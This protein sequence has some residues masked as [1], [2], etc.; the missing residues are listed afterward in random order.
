M[1]PRQTDRRTRTLL[2]AGLLLLGALSLHRL[3]FAPVPGPAELRLTGTTMGTTWS[4]RLHAGGPVAAEQARAIIEGATWSVEASMSTYRD[5][6]EVSRLS[7]HPVGQAFDLSPELLRV[8]LS[9]LELFE[10]TGGAFDATVAPLVR[11]WGF[12]AGAALKAPD[13]AMLADA[14]RSVGFDKLVL[15]RQAATATRTVEG[16]EVDLSAIAK[17]FAVD[18]AADALERAGAKNY[19]VEVGGELR[20]AGQR[21]PS[22][23]WRVGVEAPREDGTRAVHRVLNPVSGCVATSGNYRNFRDTKAG[24][25]SHIIDPRVGKPVPRRLASVTVLHPRCTQADAWATALTVLGVDEGLA[26]AERE[27][28]AALLLTHEG[29]GLREHASSRFLASK[30][31]K[32]YR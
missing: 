29:D 11:L 26:V 32:P 23:P 22:S 4:A 6:S 16:L 2:V 12:G 15:D 14:R 17:G 25:V 3:V 8:L 7:R 1:P 19:L 28:V 31:V 9:A 13:A 27:G 30:A 18:L 20:V 10:R 5:D 21:A 24:R